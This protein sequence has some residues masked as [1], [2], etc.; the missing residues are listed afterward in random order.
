MLMHHYYYYDY[1]YDCGGVHPPQH[2]NDYRAIRMFV[3]NLVSKCHVVVVVVVVAT[4]MICGMTM[5]VSPWSILR[6]DSM[7][8]WPHVM[9]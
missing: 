3:P 5:T 9:R 7:S 2:R 1:Y 8:H 4:W 6:V